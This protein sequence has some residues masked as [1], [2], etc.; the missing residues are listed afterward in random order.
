MPSSISG[1]GNQACSIAKCSSQHGNIEYCFQCEN[2]PCEKYDNIDVFGSFITYQRQKQDIEKFRE[3]GIEIYGAGQ[4]KKKALL[5][6]LLDTYNDGRRKNL[7]CIA[8]N[9]LELEDLKNIISELDENISN[10]ASKEKSV[11][12]ANLFQEA[13]KQNNIALKLRKKKR[14]LH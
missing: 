14:M 4:Q 10:F 8:V 3:L 7:F 9:L 1:A 13:A 5:S 12:A 11:Y 2:C 6:H